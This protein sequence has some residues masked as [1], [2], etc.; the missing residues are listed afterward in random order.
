MMA[1]KKF[2]AGIAISAMAI[3]AVT[4]ITNDSHDVVAESVSKTQLPETMD[5]FVETSVTARASYDAF[6]SY[7]VAKEKAQKKAPPAK[8]EAAKKQCSLLRTHSYKQCGKT[9]CETQDTCGKPCPKLYGQPAW[10]EVPLTNGAGS[11]FYPVHEVS[12]KEVRAKEQKAKEG[13]SK[14]LT[15]K[16][17]VKKEKAYK[18]KVAAE[19]GQKETAHKEHTSKEKAT[20]ELKSKERK[21]KEALEKKQEKV[22]KAT[23]LLKCD[24]IGD[25][26]EAKC[27]SD[28]AAEA[29]E[30][31]KIAAAKEVAAKDTLEKEQKA[32]YAS[33]A[34]ASEH[35]DDLANYTSGE[36]YA[37]EEYAS[38]AEYASEVAEQDAQQ[39]H[40]ANHT[41]DEYHE[42]EAAVKAFKD[43]TG[44]GSGGVATFPEDV[45]DEIHE[46]ERYGDE[47]IPPGGSRRLLSAMSSGSGDGPED[48]AAEEAATEE[49]IKAMNATLNED[50]KVLGED[51][52][53]AGQAVNQTGQDNRALVESE[54]AFNAVHAEEQD[55][56]NNA[57]LHAAKAALVESKVKATDSYVGTHRGALHQTSCP[58]EKKFAFDVCFGRNAYKG[59]LLQTGKAKE[60]RAKADAYKKEMGKDFAIILKANATLLSQEEAEHLAEEMVQNAT[61]K[62][63]NDGDA[64]I[65]AETEYKDEVARQKAA[66]AKKAAEAEEAAAAQAAQGGGNAQ[67]E[68]AVAD[69][70]A[71]EATKVEDGDATP[72]PPPSLYEAETALYAE[73][74]EE[75][76]SHTEEDQFIDTEEPANNRKLLSTS[77]DNGDVTGKCLESTN[78][79]FTSCETVVDQAYASCTKVYNGLRL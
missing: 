74:I 54:D 15:A 24:S 56:D 6:A 29:E 32:S 19:K 31:A 8:F 64:F 67:A 42:F 62:L 47:V 78:A 16:E 61:A 25:A 30:K 70:D 17:R 45:N 28:K 10:Q 22:H 7:Q 60:A 77:T 38:A 12:V 76:Y 27:I 35:A 66:E 73:L 39:R 34:Y 68:E 11:R 71:E 43:G 21:S 1:V 50:K 23:V 26:V 58:E 65:A 44:S 79:A 51:Q 63:N 4:Y 48:F 69:K 41:M 37:S 3:I 5:A 57:R 49:K 18:G 52:E 75:D 14:E 13:H 33:A 59:Q 46:A 55:A 40:V 9:Y 72:A 2:A 53:K 20:K 36:A